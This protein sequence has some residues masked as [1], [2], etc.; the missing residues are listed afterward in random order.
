MTITCFWLCGTGFSTGPDAISTTFGAALD[1]RFEFRWLPYPASYGERGVDY[2]ES[3]AIGRQ[4]LID[5]IRATPNRAVI[6]GYSQ[7]A[8]I[9]GGL[10]AEIGRGEHP[11]LD[12]MAC[13]LIADPSRPQGAGMP[14][15]PTASGYG[16]S[17]ER[18]ISGMRA[19]WAANEG[20]PIT[21]LPPGNPLRGIADMSEYFSLSSPGDAQEWMESLLARALSNRWQRWWSLENWQSWGGAVAYA[22]GYLRDGRHGPD[23]LTRGH[24][25]RLAR[26]VN[27]AV[28]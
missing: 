3:V 9:A 2:A 6:G 17:G 25:V 24:A 18:R 7:G 1:G 22:R 26:V 13:A 27:E 14:G 4:V 12:V 19:W 21:A 20:D 15:W 16:I 8:G 28:E 11:D 23:Y 10:A 5:A